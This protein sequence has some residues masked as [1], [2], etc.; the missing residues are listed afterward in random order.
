[1][2]QR[3]STVLQKKTTC[4]QYNSL[5]Y[6]CAVFGITWISSCKFSIEPLWEGSSPC[7]LVKKLYF[8]WW[9]NFNPDL[10]SPSRLDF[11]FRTHP[12]LYKEKTTSLEDTTFMLDCSKLLASLS[13]TSN[14]KDFL[15]KK[16]W[17]L[18]QKLIVFL[19][20]VKMLMRMIFYGI[21]DL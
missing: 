18:C 21:I 7:Q 15:S 14:H 9:L 2:P 1:M 5:L 8:K 6:F 17:L 20:L 16:L 3:H 10:F 4:A 12:D 19:A 11:W 13:V